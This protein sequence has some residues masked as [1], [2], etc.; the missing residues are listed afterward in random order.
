MFV[1][2]R[3]SGRTCDARDIF[4]TQK[5][6]IFVFFLLANIKNS[7]NNLKFFI[8]EIQTVRDY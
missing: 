5:L 6:T 4:G 1:N 3:K 2:C 8:E 7:L